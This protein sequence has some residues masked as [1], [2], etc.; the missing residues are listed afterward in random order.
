MLVACW[1]CAAGDW[2]SDDTGTEESGS[3]DEDEAELG[4]QCAADKAGKK[5]A[6]GAKA[7]EAAAVKGSAAAKLLDGK[8]EQG[9]EGGAEAA[10]GKE[11]G[12]PASTI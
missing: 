2:D 1:S 9:A 5:G 10:A 4:R 8:A 6:G 3:E 12:L 11:L 7:A